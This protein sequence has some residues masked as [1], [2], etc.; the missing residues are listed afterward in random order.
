MR[1]VY[2]L[3]CFGRWKMYQILFALI[4]C[5]FSADVLKGMCNK[6]KNILEEKSAL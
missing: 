5:E 3:F 6:Q 4:V 1:F 2:S